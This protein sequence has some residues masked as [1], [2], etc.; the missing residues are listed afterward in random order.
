M[1]V[2]FLDKGLP[3]VPGQEEIAKDEIAKFRKYCA[4]L[5][6][7]ASQLTEKELDDYYKS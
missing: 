3:V 2:N 1:N 5:G 6:K 7:T 4:S